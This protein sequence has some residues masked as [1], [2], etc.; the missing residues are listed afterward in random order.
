MD[1][2]ELA[3]REM[4]DG[5]GKAIPE[6]RGISTESILKTNSD[7]GRHKNPHNGLSLIKK[8]FKKKSGIS[9]CE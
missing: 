2:K 9:V 4:F 6:R 8:K 7:I 1:E 3:K 5:N